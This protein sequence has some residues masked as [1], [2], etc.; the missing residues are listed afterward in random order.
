MGETLLLSGFGPLPVQRPDS[1]ADLGRIVSEARSQ[2]Q[3]VYPVGGRTMIE[4]GLK[5]A[6]PGVAVET[7]GLNR[8]IDYPA[9]DMTVTVQA[10]ITLGELAQ[11]LA[12]ENQWLPVDVPLPGR[13]TIGGA[14][15]TNASGPRRLGHGTLRDYVIGISFVTDDGVEV[16]G[17]GRVVKNV[18]G[19]DFMKL[20][21]GALG[22][23]GIVTQVT[24]KVK[25]RPEAAAVVAFGCSSGELPAV[26]DLLHKSNSRP[27]AIELLNA[28][29][30]QAAGF[31]LMAAKAEWVVA[32]GF[33]EKRV[34][35]DWQRSTLLAELKPVVS[36]AFELS[37][38]DAERIWPAVTDLQVRPE[39][40]F[41]GKAAVLPSRTA[42]VA[43]SANRGGVL[44]HGQ[45]LNGILWQHGDTPP[46]G[47]FQ[48]RRGATRTAKTGPDWELMKHVK[49]TL[50]PDDVF[51]PGR[52]W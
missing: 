29:A 30:W 9:R 2:R 15:A 3:A 12:K 5:P 47:D 32:V 6:K 41:I 16:K 34:T 51:N 8:V 43:A 31:T 21:T 18:A 39:S 50:D 17:G 45:P 14:V 35:V 20:Q 11:V 49:K 4:L 52:L 23:L 7:L 40:A 28:A 27:A 1:V 24:L 33:E 19:Y 36:S 26:L 22:T 10:G 38:P 13:A 25:P 42:A 44:V 46:E 48:T 37:G